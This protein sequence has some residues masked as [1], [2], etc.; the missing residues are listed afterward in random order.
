MSVCLSVCM[1]ACMHAAWMYVCVCVYVC[2]YVCMYVCTYIHIQVRCGG[3]SRMRHFRLMYPFSRV[4][5]R[6]SKTMKTQACSRAH[7]EMSVEVGGGGGVS[8]PI[9]PLS[10][11]SVGRHP[12]TASLP[13]LCAPAPR[14]VNRRRYDIRVRLISPGPSLQMFKFLLHSSRLRQPAPDGLL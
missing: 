14:P 11:V 5:A 2:M 4:F 13:R 9:P 10:G 12:L 7:A 6:I 1:Y 8:H 3:W